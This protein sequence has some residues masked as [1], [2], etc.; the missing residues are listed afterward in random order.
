MVKAAGRARVIG[1][2]DQLV[3][4]D[5]EAHP[6]ALLA[7]VAVDDLLV[8]AEAELIHRERSVRGDV[9]REHIDVIEPL[10]GRSTPDVALRDV[11][12]RRLQPI[13]WVVALG[14]VVELK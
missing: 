7:A 12:Q 1:D 8:E 2:I 4:G 11:L 3:R 5:R 6:R 14:L 10:D 13:W 9:L